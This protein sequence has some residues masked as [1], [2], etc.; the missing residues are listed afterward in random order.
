M[1]G[2][3]KS[4][5]TG[6]TTLAAGASAMTAGT[7]LSAH[8][9]LALGGGGFCLGSEESAGTR[10]RFDLEA[11]ENDTYLFPSAQASVWLH[12][13]RLIVRFLE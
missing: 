9:A 13:F 10:V 4:K 5:L 1:W 7:S 6:F 11:M 8:G 3:M 2:G 12:P